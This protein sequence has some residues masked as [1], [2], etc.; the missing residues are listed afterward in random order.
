MGRV[1][2]DNWN[3]HK[4]PSTS[5]RVYSS[6]VF[7]FSSSNIVM[8]AS[9]INQ[10]YNEDCIVT[11]GR[12]LDEYIDLTVTSPPYDTLRSYGNDV[13]KTWGEQVWKPII[14][15]LYRVTKDG[16]VVVWVVG[17]ATINGSETGTSFKQALYFMECN[18]SLHDTMIFEKHNFANPSSNRYHQMF[19]YMFVFTKGK[20]KTFNPIKDK[21]N[22]YAG[23][24]TFGKNTVTQKDGSKKERDKKIYTE[25]G[26]RGNIWK[27]IVGSANGN[28]N[29]D[30]PASF[31][32]QLAQDVIVSWSKPNDLVYDPFGGSFTTAKASIGLGRNWIA[33]E[34]SSEYCDIGKERLSKARKLF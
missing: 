26:M 17:D 20:P 31:P 11:M 14:K 21:S 25:Y 9:V 12:M 18:F 24:T 33:S 13:D 34:I 3:E 4:L 15:E 2:S 23:T 6:Y 5:I 19:E 29:G 32:E 7:Y 30:H 16:G 10:I 28:D 27:Y 22:A 8:V 1:Q